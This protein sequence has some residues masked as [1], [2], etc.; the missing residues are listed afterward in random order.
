MTPSDFL[1]SL[2]P[3]FTRDKVSQDL[4]VSR[5]E[6]DSHVRPN[7]ETFKKNFKDYTLVAPAL[8]PYAQRFAN[9]ADFK[10]SGNW[11]LAMWENSIRHIPEKISLAET[12]LDG[13]AIGD[14]NRAAMSAKDM[15]VTQVSEVLSFMV[16]YSRRFLNFVIQT[17][18]NH[19]NQKPEDDKM[20]SA[21]IQWI[22]RGYG[23]FLVGLNFLAMKKM[24]VQ[25]LYDSIPDVLI[26]SNN[27]TE[28]KAVSGDNIDPFKFG[29]I[30]VKLNPIYH[31]GM[32]IAEYQAARYHEA[33][34]EHQ[35][36]S[37]K[38]MYLKQRAAGRNDA[39][40]ESVIDMY[41]AVLAKKS[42]E[43]AKLEDKYGMGT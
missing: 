4:Q 3:T 17:E 6:F 40:L 26:N 31:V 34:A 36:L 33:Q 5:E 22:N 24:K 29:I 41:D 14:F 37:T 20:V 38:I 28:V 2:L 32:R 1:S 9:T 23:A 13:S 16:R 39:Q 7:F 11:A 42:Y 27:V 8:A 25:E 30:P 18:I 10:Y 35:A 19:L 43:I 15:N 21:E 12:T